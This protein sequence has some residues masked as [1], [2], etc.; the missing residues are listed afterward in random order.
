MIRHAGLIAAWS[1]AGWRGVLIEGPSGCGKS[2]LALRCCGQAG[3]RLVA[4][5]RV[6]L[7][8][9]GGELFGAAP[10]PLAGLLE[11]R[12]VGVLPFE[13]LRFA[14]VALIVRCVEGPA[15]VERCPGREAETILGQEVPSLSLWPHDGA[16]PA[17][18]RRGLETLGAAGRTAYLPPLSPP[19]RRRGP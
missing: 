15:A 18:L 6:H 5:D 19:D 1:E 2:D 13:S 7:F 11:T 10:A 9:S 4:D 3:W 12:G 8:L 16:A 17:K 14:R